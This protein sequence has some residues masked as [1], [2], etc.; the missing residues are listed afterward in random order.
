MFFSV[1]LYERRHDFRVR[2]AHELV[3]SFCQLVFERAVIFDYAVMYYR[4]LVVHRQVRVRVDFA[5]YA[6]RCPARV[7]YAYVRPFE[8]F[9]YLFEIGYLAFCLGY[10]KLFSA[11]YGDTGRIVTSVLQKLKLFDEHFLNVF[12][13]EISYY[14][15]HTVFS[16]IAFLF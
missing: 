2:F 4:P 5:R 15:A 3:A 9:Y 12:S 16:F 7:R 11:F 14:S 10:L 6:V 1:I 13:S 8:R